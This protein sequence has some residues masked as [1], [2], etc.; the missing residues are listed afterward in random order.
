MPSVVGPLPCLNER[1]RDVT[2]RRCSVVLAV[3]ALL[4]A[5]PAAAAPATAH[6]ADTPTTHRGD[7]YPSSVSTGPTADKPQSKLW[8]H[9]GSWWAL[10]ISDSDDKVHV[11]RLRSDHEWEDTGTVVDHRTTARGD[12][13]EDGSQVYV[14]SRT[15]SG[16]L[17]MARLSYDESGGKYRL[18]DGYP[19]PIASGGAE[20]VTIAR[21]SEKRLWATYTQDSK[22]WVTHSEGSDGEWAEPFEPPVGDTDIDSDDI[23][24]IVELD[25]KVGVMWSDQESDKFRF[26]THDDSHDPTE[27]WGELE[28]ALSGNN[29]ADDHLNL[30]N[31]DSTSDGRLFAAIKTSQGDGSEPDDAPS[32]MVLERSPGGDWTS[33]VYSTVADKATRPVL[34]IDEANRRIFVMATAPEGG[35]TIYYKTASLD[36]ISFGPGRGEPFMEWDG[37]D[38]NDATTTKQTVNASTDLVVLASDESDDR[39]YHT[40]LD[41]SE[42]EDPPDGDPP[43]T[44]PPSVPDGLD[45]AR[46]ASSTVELSWER[47]TDNEAVTGYGVYRDGELIATTADPGYT[48]DDAPGGESY[49]YEVDAI[50]EAG[51]RS[52]RS[53]PVEV[54]AAAITL[55]GSSFAANPTATRLTVAAPAGAAA[56]NTLVA[57]LDVRGNTTITPP[58]GWKLLRRD[59]RGT[60][61]TKATYYRR[62]ASTEPSSYTWRLSSSRAASGGILSYAGVNSVTPV[63]AFG[64]RV[65]AASKSLTAPSITTVT[66]STRLIGLFGTAVS[67]TVAPPS[68]MAEVGEARST[69]G[70]YKVTSE[71]AEVARAP[72]GATGRRSATAANSAANIGHMVALRP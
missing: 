18:D 14:A 48:D 52:D 60:V 19:V 6:A 29:M 10:M 1:L 2:A 69:A 21:D 27:G 64:G 42:G 66:P 49:S 50:D 11:F 59:V 51:N 15:S 72:T 68:D 40:E 32:I 9:D 61:M 39:Y 31:I 7:N 65:N 12:A 62:T 56:G 8:H 24:S 13:L 70:S 20:S 57:S 3:A 45:A 26:V 44:E 16:S 34:A 63:D 71:A 30:R 46:S 5:L 47:S 23:S 58:A 55:R 37:A 17:R 33:H 35:G 67:T 22:V 25:G 38:L 54:I 28:T 36:D 41:I 53:D 43:D 4:L